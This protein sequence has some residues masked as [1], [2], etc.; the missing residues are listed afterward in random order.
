MVLVSAWS[1]SQVL[2]Y[3]SDLWLVAI[4]SCL[5]NHLDQLDLAFQKKKYAGLKTWVSMETV[6]FMAGTYSNSLL[7]V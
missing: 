1:L 5:C 3:F 7:E 6:M 4:Y 2:P